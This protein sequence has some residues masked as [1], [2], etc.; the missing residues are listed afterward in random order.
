M[1]AVCARTPRPAGVPGRIRL[2]SERLL[3][4]KHTLH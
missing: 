2:L 4:F 1:H 3:S